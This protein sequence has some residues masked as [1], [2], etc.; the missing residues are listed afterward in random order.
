MDKSYSG[1]LRRSDGNHDQAASK[2]LHPVCFDRV[3]VGPATRC[4]VGSPGRILIVRQRGKRSTAD[5]ILR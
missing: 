5:S 3:P 2:A 1:Q 4:Q